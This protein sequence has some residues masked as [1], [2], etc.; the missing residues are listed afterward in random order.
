LACRA[1]RYS[2]KAL[3]RFYK[4]ARMTMAPN[5]EL[6]NLIAASNSKPCCPMLHGV[7]LERFRPCRRRRE[8]GVFTI[9]YVGR[10]TSEKNVRR[11]GEIES[12]LKAVGARNYRFVLVGDGGERSWLEQNIENAELPGVLRGDLLAETFAG[13]DAFVFPS[14]TDTFGLVVLEAMASGVPPI[15]ARGGG[16]QY[17][18]TE[19]SDGYVVDSTEGFVEAIL[20]LQRDSAK[21]ARMRVAAR[22]HACQNSWTPVFDQVHEA[23]RTYL[24]SN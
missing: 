2:L 16:P 5:L 15:V 8:E 19:G 6:V 22:A 21:L 1:E 13:F 11:I 18:V 14:E 7:D 4:I 23:Y 12:M 3:L 9:G 17:Q 24:F 10:L 20:E